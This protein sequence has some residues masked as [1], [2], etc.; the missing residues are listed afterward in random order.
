MNNFVGLNE[1]SE[2]F[3]FKC[4]VVNE[5]PGIFE[6]MKWMKYSSSGFTLRVRGDE[7]SCVELLIR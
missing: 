6:W 1:Y 5:K 2:M 7:L 4:Y 3:V